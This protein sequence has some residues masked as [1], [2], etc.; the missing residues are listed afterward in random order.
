[1]KILPPDEPPDDAFIDADADTV[2]NAVDD[3]EHMWKLVPTKDLPNPAALDV[4]Q[5]LGLEQLLN[6][7][8]PDINAKSST[9]IMELARREMRKQSTV[10][11]HIC[12]LYTSPS[13]R[14]RQKSRMPSSA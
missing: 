3:L 7:T 1:M 10:L 12:L 5:N 13:P 14:D 6:D 2:I 9:F 11:T 4:A 8:E